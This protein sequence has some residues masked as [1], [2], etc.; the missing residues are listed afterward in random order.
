M[1][2]KFEIKDGSLTWEGLKIGNLL[3]GEEI[4]FDELKAILITET[5]FWLGRPIEPKT[6]Q[7]ITNDVSQYVNTL[8]TEIVS[9]ETKL[10]EQINTQG[11]FIEALEHRIGLLNQENNEL[12]K[13]SRSS[14]KTA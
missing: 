10:K 11:A 7:E 3:N 5:R 1:K 14:D 12:R 9:K 2:Y 8:N 13:L 4:S 6:L